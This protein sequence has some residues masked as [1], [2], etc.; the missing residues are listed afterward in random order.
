MTLQTNEKRLLLILAFV[1]IFALSFQ[2][3]IFPEFKK[4]MVISEKNDNLNLAYDLLTN[5]NGKATAIENKFEIKNSKLNSLLGRDVSGKLDDADLD[6]YFTK[7]SLIHGLK[8]SSLTIEYPDKKSK[9]YIEY[10]TIQ[11]VYVT[12]GVEGSMEQLIALMNDIGSKNF[13][14]IHELNTY[15]T[16]GVYKH[17]LKI[18]L[19][20]L[21]G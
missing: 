5:E 17:T 7:M 2:Y 3:L 6:V 8:P 20:M 14:K 1:A 19:V 10:Q 11:Q 12:I 4:N 13:L 18:E 21:K 16:N 9:D 15:G